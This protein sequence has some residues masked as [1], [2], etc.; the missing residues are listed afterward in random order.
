MGIAALAGA[1]TLLAWAVPGPDRS[2]TSRLSEVGLTAQGRFGFVAH[3]R[4]R[5]SAPDPGFVLDGAFYQPD[6]AQGFTDPARRQADLGRLASLGG[7]TLW[8]Q[9]LAHGDHSLLDPWPERVDPVRG[10]LDDAEE[11]GLVVWLGTRE[12]PRLWDEG[13]VPLGVWKD[14]GDRALAVAEE[15][16]ARY[17][18]HPAFAGWYWTP[19]VVWPGEPG[20][21]RARRLGR[22]TSDHLRRLRSL[23]PG[24]PVAMAFGPGGTLG[25]EVPAAG[26]C[27]LMAAARP[28]VVVLMDGVGTGHV[29]VTQLDALYAAA[30]GCAARVGAKLVADV[31]VFGEGHPP[32]PGRLRAQMEIAWRRAD[33]VVAFDLPHHL[34]PDSV[35]VALWSGARPL[36][37]AL[38]V[39]EERQPAGDWLVTAPSLAT[40]DLVP[41]RAAPVGEVELVTR[42]PHPHEVSVAIDQGAGLTP[43]GSLVAHA[44]PGRDELTWRWRPPVEAAADAG[45]SAP[46]AGVVRARLTLLPGDGGLDV[47]A[48]RL[49]AR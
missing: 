21:A 10:L 23:V 32:D 46:P 12:D 40:V 15:A 16:A 24:A 22:I 42:A 25:S 35:G 2:P 31:E 28:D 41:T 36:R 11:Q 5:E 19:E 7:T 6:I 30:A 49:R 37:D 45:E 48:A 38:D 17:G 9:Y 14:A 34:A 43:R 3:R 20:P 39:T 47:L 8:L 27:R 26:W 13:E 33:A 18:D 4:L 29:D 1:A 44:G